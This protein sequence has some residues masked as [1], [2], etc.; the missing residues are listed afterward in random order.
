MISI[1]ELKDLNDRDLISIIKDVNTPNFTY[2]RCCEILLDR[3]EKQMYK[4]WW[5]LQRQLNKLGNRTVTQED[6]FDL[7]YEAF[8]IAIQ[9]TDVSK[10]E[11]DNWKFVGMLN[12]YL[13]N[14]RTKIIKEVKNK[15]S[16]T[17]SLVNMALK[18][19]ESSSVVDTDVEMHYQE[20]EGYKLNPEYEYEMSEGYNN[21]SKSIEACMKNWSDFEK[22][23][24]HLLEDGNSKAEISRIL[25]VEPSKVYCASKK[26]CKELKKHLKYN[27]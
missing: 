27:S 5:V 13:T 15:W 21:C 24:F 7:A 17:K 25:K 1:S 11:N 18:D 14:V 4:N 2:Q 20:S 10:I 26:M 6:Y 8:F 23:V 9:K 22:D 16:R 19:N 3:Y 12:W